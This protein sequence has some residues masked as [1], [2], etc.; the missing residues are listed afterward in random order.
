[1]FLK[2]TYILKKPNEEMTLKCNSN[3]LTQKKKKLKD[4]NIPQL[5]FFLEIICNFVCP[6]R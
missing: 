2:M 3:I 1:M 6:K 5:D 4:T